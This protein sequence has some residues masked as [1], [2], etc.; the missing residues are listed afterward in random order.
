[1]KS[2]YPYTVHQLDDFVKFNVACP[3]YHNAFIRKWI[4]EYTGLY[5]VC[6]PVSE[7][8]IYVVVQ[9]LLWN[10]LFLNWDKIV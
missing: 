10:N 2:C 9:F 4:G 6:H 8:E 1:M 5:H 3:L 7:C